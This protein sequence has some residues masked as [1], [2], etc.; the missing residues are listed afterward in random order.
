[1]TSGDQALD[2]AAGTWACVHMAVAAFQ[3]SVSV[4]SVGEAIAAFFVAIAAQGSDAF[5]LGG[6]GVGVMAIFTYNAR[7]AVHAGA[8]L[9]G[10]LLMASGA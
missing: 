9:I 4:G 2:W 6:L 5:G 10:G 1:M 8:P 3:T 7:S